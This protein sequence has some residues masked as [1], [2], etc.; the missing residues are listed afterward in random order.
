MDG[1]GT[2]VSCSLQG[3]QEIKIDILKKQLSDK[4]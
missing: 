3:Q 4:A 2:Q 1:E